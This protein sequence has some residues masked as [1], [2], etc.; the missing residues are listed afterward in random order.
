[1]ALTN[2]TTKKILTKNNHGKAITRII[3]LSTPTL[4]GINAEIFNEGLCWIAE[5]AQNIVE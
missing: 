3:N 2:K 1:M 4:L 5:K